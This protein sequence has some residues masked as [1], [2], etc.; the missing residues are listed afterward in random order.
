MIRV[1]LTK[2]QWLVVYDEQRRRRD[3]FSCIASMPYEVLTELRSM[4][5]KN[6]HNTVSADV[7]NALF[8]IIKRFNFLP[9][10]HHTKM[11]VYRLGVEPQYIELELTDDQVGEITARYG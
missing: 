1:T 7:S 4:D 3:F 10:K 5:F 11:Y 8:D 9:S 2:A 6:S